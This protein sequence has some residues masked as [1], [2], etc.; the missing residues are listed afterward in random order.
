VL[1][2]TGV[3]RLICFHGPSKGRARERSFGAAGDRLKRAETPGNRARRAR[4]AVEPSETVRNRLKQTARIIGL[5]H[6]VVEHKERGLR[7]PCRMISTIGNSTVWC[8]CSKG[9][10]RT[11]SEYGARGGRSARFPGV[12][13]R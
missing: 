6:R 10:L 11:T 2:R 8:V 9:A 1:R 7:S 5:K 13:R 3:V 4:G 12:D